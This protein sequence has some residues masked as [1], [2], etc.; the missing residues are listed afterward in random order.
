MAIVERPAEPVPSPAGS[1]LLRIPRAYRA[2]LVA[3]GLF[4][5]LILVRYWA[6][7]PDLTSSGL[8]GA[9]LVLMLPILLAGLGGLW[10]ERTGVVNI[11]L[12]GM[13]ILGTWFGAWAGWKWGPWAGVVGGILGGGM[14]GLIHAV[15][16]VTFGIDQ[17]VSGVAINIIAGGAARFL[18]AVAYRNP[19]TGGS[20]TQS[21]QVTGSPIGSF[22][23]PFLSG[24]HLFGWR[25]PDITGWL[26]D[27]H[28]KVVSDIAGPIHGLTSNINWL[29]L[30]AILLVPASWFV[31][32]R[33]SLGLRM[34]SAGE[35]PMAAE[36]LGVAVYRMKY[37]GVVVSGML[38][39]LG[40]AILVLESAGIYREGQTAGRGFI[41]L[42]AVIFG[43]WRPM[44][45][46]GAAGLFGYADTLRL[47]SAASPHGL[48][49]FVAILLGIAFFYLVILRRKWTAGAIVG[50]IA[51]ATAFWYINTNQVPQELLS[52]T[53]HLVTLLV[54]SLA[55]Q[56]LRPPAT[57]G[58]PYRRGQQI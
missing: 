51:A 46:L 22:S 42:A 19:A 53:P 44:G 54:L 35:H 33:T 32:W 34:R 15:A 26:A 24:G 48:V 28:I 55:S 16:T 39:G 36:S 21:P 20:A 3:V 27:K 5:L 17:V 4:G 41:G 56:R 57:D 8:F 12:E 29:T 1:P 6:N 37:I 43:N 23:V 11:G 9:A 47:R 31:L 49:L 50:V 30:I 45:V 10:S 14:G 18:S 13:L 38:A 58:R 7:V 52:F 40:G 2:A 25:T